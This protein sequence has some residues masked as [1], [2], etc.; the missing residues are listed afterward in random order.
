MTFSQLVG[1]FLLLWQ[2]KKCLTLVHVWVGWCCECWRFSHWLTWHPAALSYSSVASK[3]YE[4]TNQGRK[5][6]SNGRQQATCTRDFSIGG[7]WGLL[8]RVYVMGQ[9]AKG[10]LHFPFSEV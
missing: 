5:D 2:T 9:G 3:L 4:R 7:H 1:V 10:I 6:S 8:P